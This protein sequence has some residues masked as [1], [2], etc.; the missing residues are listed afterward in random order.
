MLLADRSAPP[1]ARGTP[2]KKGGGTMAPA[3]ETVKHGS[4]AIVGLLKERLRSFQRPRK[5]FNPH[6]L[7]GD[8]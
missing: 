3:Q 6:Q 4:C 7:V 2:P 1:G 8:N 5:L